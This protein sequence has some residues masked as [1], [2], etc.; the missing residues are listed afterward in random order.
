MTSYYFRQVPLLLEIDDS[1]IVA[2]WAH[3]TMGLIQQRGRFMKGRSDKDRE[4]EEKEEER[5]VHNI[6]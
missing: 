2:I 5:D 4:G 3:N 1:Q 6:E